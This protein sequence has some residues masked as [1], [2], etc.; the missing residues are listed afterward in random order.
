M[1]LT[2]REIQRRVQA[3][4]QNTNAS[5]SNAD[6][7]LPKIKDWINIRYDRVYRSFDW[8]CT[9]ETQDL[10]IVASQQEYI[11]NRDIG[12]IIS[13]FDRT[14]GVPVHEDT[15]ENHIRNNGIDFDQTGNIQRDDP[16]RYRM[17]G[18]YT[19]RNE[20]GASAET[21]N[22]VSTNNTTDIAPNVVRIVGLVNGV[23]IGENITLTGTTTATSINTY[24]ANQKLKVSVGTS[25]GTRNTIVG[26]ITASGTTSSTIFSDIAPTEFAHMYRW[27]RVSPQPLTGATQ[28][29][30]EVWYQKVLRFLEDNNDITVIDC[31]M[32]L[33]QG[34][35]ADSLREDGL[36][37]EASLAEQKFV[38]MVQELQSAQRQPNLMEQ[39]MPETKRP[40]KI[41]DFGRV[42]TR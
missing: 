18:E 36:E 38:S 26:K 24:D 41:L 40:I 8:I 10:Q 23:E 37:Q 29:V 15:I 16:S 39:F 12:K 27:I 32:E 22:V 5:T 20:I 9:T 1:L 6:D 34:A 17:V 2:F 11:F 33:V 30:W 21:I 35:F 4:I 7:L 14:N 42:V 3:K 13:I 31:G 28:P 19:V 25:D